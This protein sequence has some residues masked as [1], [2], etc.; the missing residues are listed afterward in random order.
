MIVD[1]YQQ[2]LRNV[3]LQPKKVAKVAK[4]RSDNVAAGWFSQY[5]PA[6]SHLWDKPATK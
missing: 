1:A 3:E 6:L 4:T 5:V 2:I